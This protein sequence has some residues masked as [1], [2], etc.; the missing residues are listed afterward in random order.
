[1]TEK[2]RLILQ[3]LSR[4]NTATL[5]VAAAILVCAAVAYATIPDAAGVIHGCYNT[6]NGNLRVID[7][8][9]GQTCKPVEAPLSW[10][11]AG[12]PGAPG[13]PGAPGE[14]GP[15]GPQGPEGPAGPEGPQ[16]PP[17]TALAYAHVNPDG[18]FD[19]DSGNI[20]V[21]HSGFP[22]MYCIG[23][24]GGVPQVAVAS[25]DSLPNVGGSV[26]AGVFPASICAGF[27]DASQIMVITRPHQQ[28]GGSAG[29]DRAFYILIN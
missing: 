9:A 18:S 15:Q 5:T 8:G 21:R 20:S 4:A 14:T 12:A 6:V 19:Q 27:P 1:M 16:G 25:L 3:W 29:A 13:I 26:Q 17:G 23:I 28:D 24:T 2:R 11:Q 7:V 22:G 10:N